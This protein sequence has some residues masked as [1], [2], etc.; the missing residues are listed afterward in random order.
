[1]TPAHHVHWA[2]F[3]PGPHAECDVRAVL[4]RARAW[5]AALVGGALAVALVCWAVIA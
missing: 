4:P 5:F 2:A 1:M 3:Q